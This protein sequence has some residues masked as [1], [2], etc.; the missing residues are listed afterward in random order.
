MHSEYVPLS[1]LGE[2][3]RARLQQ[4]SAFNGAGINGGGALV[5]VSD[6]EHTT[7]HALND[8]Q[9]TGGAAA[10]GGFPLQVAATSQSGAG[11]SVINSIEPVDE[12]EEIINDPDWGVM[13]SEGAELRDILLETLVVPLASYVEARRLRERPSSSD[14]DDNAPPPASRQRTEEP[15]A[16]EAWANG[17]L[18]G[19]AEAGHAPPADA[20]RSL[21]A[22]ED[23]PQHQSLGASDAGQEPAPPVMRS[24]GSDQ[25]VD[26]PVLRS[27]ASAP[28]AAAAPA[29]A[30]VAPSPRRRAPPLAPSL[31]SA[32][33]TKLV[34]IAREMLRQRREKG[35][36]AGGVSSMAAEELED[37]RQWIRFHRG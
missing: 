22:G 6:D 13:G 35:G 18:D 29:A 25:E 12:L 21:S 37:L 11:P 16:A 7:Q 1:R 30:Q 19:S 20:F 10:H 28:L 26:E 14:G 5:T 3:H 23:T 34:A 8:S 15:A 4:H 31:R 9:F 17:V 33:M 36:A 27:A 32:A 2:Q 24:L